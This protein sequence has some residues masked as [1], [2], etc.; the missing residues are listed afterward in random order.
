VRLRLLAGLAL[1]GLVTWVSAN[2]LVG[3]PHRAAAQTTAFEIRRA[4]KA[5]YLPQPGRDRLIVVLA[6]GSDARVGE[7]VH[8]M[9]ADS[10][11][12]IVV[13]PR[14][15][16][17]TILGFPRDAYVNIPGKGTDKINA[18]MVLGGPPLLARTVQSITGI[19][20]D[21]WALSSFKGFSR[22]VKGV[23]GLTVRVRYPM[24]DRAAGTHFKRGKR[25]LTGGQALAFSR[26][27][28]SPPDGDF[29]RSRNQGVLMLAALKKFHQEFQDNP[30]ALFRWL[31][32]G[33][34]GVRTDLSLGELIDLGLLAAQINPGKVRNVVVNGSV[35]M[36]GSASV[37]HLSGSAPAL[38][39]D[40][41]EDGILNR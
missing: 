35:G 40:I 26:D 16:A 30:A 20:I 36:A 7:V 32:A 27:R 1:L 13:N 39:R 3:P 21:Y 24:N 31:R 9:R 19:R 33:L 25:K 5:D 23:R 12:L 34:G 22:I 18:A 8:R 29:G 41:R 37:V 10:I 15:R 2:A 4:Q 6:I 14:K 11:H 17:G 28:H 38:Y